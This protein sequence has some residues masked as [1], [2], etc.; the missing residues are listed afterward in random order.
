[1]RVA[2]FF[3]GNN[4]YRTMEAAVGNIELDYDSLAKWVVHQVAGQ[5]G[6]FVGAYYYTG[7]DHSPALDRFLSGL[8]LRHGYFVRREA[9]VER[10]QTCPH[11]NHESIQH[12]EKRVDTRMV[13]EMV[14]LAATNAFD[15]AV[16]F[17]GDADLVPAIETL[18]MFGRRVDIASW[19]GF[20]VAPDLLS[21]S[22]S[23]IDLMDGLEQFS[24]GRARQ[25]ESV[26]TPPCSIEDVFNQVLQ[27]CEY[28]SN[29]D[30]HLAR[31]YFENR[32]KA[33]GPCPPPGEPRQRSL[34]QLIEQGRVEIF[35]TSMNGRIIYAVRPRRRRG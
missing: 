26:E 4:F 14:R 12:V 24:T 10:K 22:F 15:C 21:Q 28:F 7:V 33:S 31:W 35:E 8:E 20:A 18:S 13:A 11:C 3:D 9:V 16:V 29:R 23:A 19:G 27:A 1:M 34:N 6:Q 17:S 25:N 2:L 30:A 32:W 5:S